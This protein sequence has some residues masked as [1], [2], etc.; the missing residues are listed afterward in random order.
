MDTPSQQSLSEIDESSKVVPKIFVDYSENSTTECTENN[1]NTSLLRRIMNNAKSILTQKCASLHPSLSSEEPTKE[2]GEYFSNPTDFPTGKVFKET[3][4]KYTSSDYCMVDEDTITSTFT[5]SKKPYP[6]SI[7]VFKRER[8]CK[9]VS[10]SQNTEDDL[11]LVQP[12]LSNRTLSR[13]SKRAY[14][15]PYGNAEKDFNGPFE[16]SEFFH[17]DDT[18]TNN[19]MSEGSLA[20]SK[21]APSPKSCAKFEDA[22]KM[23]DCNVPCRDDSY[24]DSHS[25]SISV[26]GM[27]GE[28]ETL[29]AGFKDCMK[30]AS[31]RSTEPL[32]PACKKPSSRSISLEE[33]R[34]LDIPDTT[35]NVRESSQPGKNYGSQDDGKFRIDVEISNFRSDR[36]TTELYDHATIL[37]GQRSSSR[38]LASEKLAEKRKSDHR[39]DNSPLAK[40]KCPAASDYKDQDNQCAFIGSPILEASNFKMEVRGKKCDNGTFGES[41]TDVISREKNYRS[42]IQGFRNREKQYDSIS[43]SLY[44]INKD[45]GELESTTKALKSENAALKNEIMEMRLDLKHTLEKVQGPMRLKLEAE[46]SR[47]HQLQQELQKAFQNMVVS[48]ENYLREMNVLKKQLCMAGTNM[49]ELEQM[50]KKLKEEMN[51]MDMLCAKLEDDLIQQKLNEAETIK[52]LTHKKYI[53]GDNVEFDVMSSKQESNLHDI[54]R[55]LSKTIKDCVPCADCAIGI[56]AEL[57]GAAKL[58]KELT[59][60]VDSRKE[61]LSYEFGESSVSRTD[62]SCQSP[63]PMEEISTQ[64]KDLRTIGTVVSMC[65]MSKSNILSHEG[66]PTLLSRSSGTRQEIVAHVSQTLTPSGCLKL[67]SASSKRD[68]WTN[69]CHSTKTPAILDKLSSVLQMISASNDPMMTDKNSSTC[70]CGAAEEKSLSGRSRGKAEECNNSIATSNNS[71]NSS[72]YSSQFPDEMGSFRPEI[73]EVDV[74]ESDTINGRMENS[75]GYDSK[76]DVSSKMRVLKRD[77]FS[78]ESD[79]KTA[80]EKSDMDS[81]ETSKKRSKLSVRIDPR[82]I[83]SKEKT[84]EDISEASEGYLREEAH[85]ISNKTQQDIQI[86]LLVDTKMEMCESPPDNLNVTTS[87]TESGNLLILTEGPSG[88]I[89]TVLHYLDDGTIEVVT[90]ITDLTKSQSSK[91]FY[92]P[93]AFKVAESADATSEKGKKSEKSEMDLQQ[94]ISTQLIVSEQ[95]PSLSE[96]F[97][98]PVAAP[99][100]DELSKEQEDISGQV[101]ICANLK[102][103][104]RNEECVMY[105]DDK[106][107]NTLVVPT[108][109]NG[110]LLSTIRNDVECWT[111]PVK[112]IDIICGPSKSSFLQQTERFA[113]GQRSTSNT[114][115]SQLNPDLPQSNPD[116]P[117]PVEPKPMDDKP[118][119][120]EETICLKE[121]FHKGTCTEKEVGNDA[122]TDTMINYIDESTTMSEEK[123]SVQTSKG[124]GKTREEIKEKSEEEMTETEQTQENTDDLRK[125]LEEILLRSASILSPKTSKPASVSKT[126]ESSSKNQV[127]IELSGKSLT[128]VDDSLTLF[129]IDPNQPRRVSNK[130]RSDECWCPTPC[131]CKKNALPL[132]L[133]TSLTENETSFVTDFD[134]AYANVKHGVDKNKQKI[135]IDDVFKKKSS[136]G[137]HPVDCECV[138]CICMPLVRQLATTKEFFVAEDNKQI[139]QMTAC[140]SPNSKKAFLMPVQKC[141]NESIGKWDYYL[142]Y[143]YLDE[144]TENTDENSHDEPIK[145]K[146][147]KSKSKACCCT[148]DCV[149]DQCK[150]EMMKKEIQKLKNEVNE[151]KG[152][153][154]KQDLSYLDDFNSKF[155]LESRCPEDCIC[156]KCDCTLTTS[157]SDRTIKGDCEEP[158]WPR[159]TCKSPK[160]ECK[161]CFFAKKQMK[162]YFTNHQNNQKCHL[163]SGPICKCPLCTCCGDTCNCEETRNKEENLAPFKHMK[164]FEKDIT[165]SSKTSKRGNNCWNIN[166]IR[167]Q[168]KSHST[169]NLLS[170]HPCAHCFTPSSPLR[171]EK[172][173][174]IN[175]K[176]GRPRSPRRVNTGATLTT[177]SKSTSCVYATTTK[178]ET[179]DDI[180]EDCSSV[181]SSIINT[182]DRSKGNYCKDQM[183]E[184]QS[185]L[186]NIKSVCSEAEE[187]AKKGPLIKQCSTFG[188]TM[189]GLKLALNNL[190]EKCKS[191]DMLIEAMT[192]ELRNRTSSISFLEVLDKFCCREIPGDCENYNDS[193]NNFEER[194]SKAAKN[195]RIIRKMKGVRTCKCG[196]IHNDSDYKMVDL[197]EFEITDISKVTD[198]SVIIK[199]NRPKSDLVTGY[200]I[201]IN[202]VNKSKVMS[203]GRTTAMIHSIDLSKNIQVS[204]HVVTKC[205]ICEPPAVAVYYA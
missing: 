124:D 8:E 53:G 185:V 78:E 172:S 193:V 138:D 41:M 24:G 57:K 9:T 93:L 63:P 196:K 123:L 59:D 155:N 3:G 71:N 39:I 48:E 191:K 103:V 62:T 27:M 5:T 142:H 150:I 42:H 4:L 49:D 148:R 19:L 164:K 100:K 2:T 68:S 105:K 90:Q 35:K 118:K 143:P 120:N 102:C 198:D 177:H 29:S 56:P 165:F 112:K 75:S 146:A 37:R 189:S 6:T 97:H 134:V 20:Q 45:S 101:L 81:E 154:Q 110:T 145:N 136:E 202:G 190:Q 26:Q 114:D 64:C 74:D 183:Q 203:G 72:N 197:K 176:I 133:E 141:S 171:A 32:E 174:K 91:R 187:K 108:V 22:E 181:D 149:C 36:K 66:N 111:C 21:L 89:E 33:K 199:W 25:S 31:N 152:I 99:S 65:L 195:E 94:D 14:Q 106:S 129:D 85:G 166:T 184:I 188:Q 182:L 107:C 1:S 126:V 13:S 201:F 83:F 96:R 86:P 159:L 119:M 151:L 162:S 113:I 132:E 17:T 12:L 168:R 122:G 80:N 116:L 186:N 23:P 109:S 167:V 135:S 58:I 73:R 88:I 179:S 160:N 34:W 11:Q 84:Q 139:Y 158:K 60:M 43:N 131:S 69:S 28:C 204:I 47:C 161:D 140:S 180:F 46:K 38:R 54:A 144:D 130:F 192:G 51:I 128:T 157:M 61:A 127:T 200:D 178:I 153:K 163:W 67:S 205:G 15:F 79:V 95:S 40:R 50:N 7:K 194:K 82:P 115:L 70:N 175:A 55:K 104:D 156:T 173:S 16:P 98:E 117:E 76:I 125:Q 77:S 92:I 30:T 10:T 52:R 44:G 170:I 137:K 18:I 121:I 169:S 147:D 87:V